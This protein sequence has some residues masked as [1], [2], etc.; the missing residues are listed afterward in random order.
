MT[1]PSVF[2]LQ[3]IQTATHALKVQRPAYAPM[4]DF[5]EK[6]FMAQHDSKKRLRIE[7]IVLSENI[8]TAKSKEKFPLINLNQFVIDIGA[9]KSLFKQICEISLTA[10]E[11]IS[12]AAKIILAAIEKKEIDVEPMLLNLLE[13]DDAFFVKQAES[14]DIDKAIL[15]F[16]SYISIQPSL[17]SCAAQLSE[18]LD[19]DAVW[20]QGYC[21]VCGNLPGLSL[22]GD[23]GQRALYCSFCWHHWMAERIYCPFCSTKEA[24]KLSYLY[25]EEEPEYRVDLCDH[26]RK[27]IK[28]V[29]VRQAERIVYPPLE[30]IVTLHLDIQAQEK[31]FESP[32]Y[33]LI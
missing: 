17:A 9:S 26:C 14:L 29:D 27:Y 30:Q 25:N 2:S 15:A 20:N 16:V 31:G 18:Y 4:L 24:E 23:K 22:L 13:G 33:L 1:P 5:Y 12:T 8:L 28:A 19:K 6:V 3:Q 32:I 10:N 7:P 11:Y 21:P